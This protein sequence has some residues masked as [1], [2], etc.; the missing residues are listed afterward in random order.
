[1]NTPKNVTKDSP[2]ATRCFECGELR[3]LRIESHAFVPDGATAD[4][5][6]A[7]RVCSCSWL[8]YPHFGPDPFPLRSVWADS[9]PYAPSPYQAAV[10]P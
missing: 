2:S 10:K 8:G 3:Y 6:G 9:Y 4:E 5:R 7:T 1:M